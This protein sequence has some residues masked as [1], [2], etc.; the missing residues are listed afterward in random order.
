MAEY[1]EILEISQQ[2]TG[3]EIKTAY[4]KLALKYH[5]DRNPGDT[6][7]EEQFKKLNEAYAVLSDEQKRA[8]YDRYGSVNGEAAFSGDIFDIFASVFGG[9]GGFHQ[10]GRPRQHVGEDLETSV[11]ITLEQARDGDTIDIEIDRLAACERCDGS[12]EEPD[13]PGRTTCGTCHGAGQVQNRT[14]SIFGMISTASM[15]P[16]CHGDGEIITNPCTRC[17][18]RGREAKTQNVSMQLP[19]G[20]D[21]GYRVRMSGE[22]N[23]GID[24]APSGDL[25]VDINLERH[26]YLVRDGDDVHYR[27]DVGFAQAAL[28]TMQS[29]FT[30]D[31]DYEFVVPPGTQSTEQ[32]R[33]RG[34]GMPRLR[35][36]G[37]GDQVITVVVNTPKALDEEARKHL[38]AY[39]QSMGEKIHRPEKLHEKVKNFFSSKKAE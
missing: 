23:I 30:L 21:E 27:L 11:T 19:K 12:R 15:C 34:K 3:S 29:V 20:I 10:A 1:Y 2:A 8:H 33:L 6:A 22:G 7:A 39:A 17:N 36:T 4:R 14:Q 32:F 9:G 35:N 26:E 16:T 5:P 13:N 38:E 24:N 18:G 37:S 31:G 25:Y 28:G